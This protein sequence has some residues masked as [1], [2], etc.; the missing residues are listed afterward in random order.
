[1]SSVQNELDRLLLKVEKPARYIGGE[2]H[3]VV[4]T[5]SADTVRFAFCFPDLYEIGMS[6]MGLN[7]LYHLLNRTD[8]TYCERCFTPA[9]D[10]SAAMK[11]AGV[12]LFTLETKTPLREMDFV[13]FTLQYELCYTN[14]LAMLDLAGIPALSKDRGEEDPIVICGGPCVYNAEPVADFM[15]VIL[16]G[17]GEELLPEICRIWS[18]YKGSGRSKDEF[19]K[20]IAALQ[21]VYIPKFYEPVRDE[22]GTFRGYR[23]LWDGAPDRVLKAIVRD[24]D[25]VDFPKEL[26]VPLIEVVHDRAVAELFRGCTRGCRFC[27]AGM[28]YRPVRERSMEKVIDIAKTQLENSGQGELSLLSLSTSD[29]TQFEPLV[30]ELMQYCK[31]RQVSLSL[32]SLRMDNFSFRVLD[33]I[34]GVRKTG[35][36]FAAEAGT[37]RLRDVI[38]KNVTEE[39]IFTALKQAFDLG[40][41]SV[42]LYFMM[43]L[44]TETYEDLDGIVDLARRIMELAKEHNGGK[45]GRYSVSVSVSNFVPKP[46]TPFMWVRQNTPEEFELKHYYLKDRL[47]KIK[48]VNFRYHGSYAS[49][50]EAVFAR[51]GRELSAA[52]LRAY[53]LGAS[54]DAWTEGFR[55]DAWEQALA[56]CG[57]DGDYFAL[58]DIDPDAP[59]PWDIVDCGITKDFFKE[60]WRRAQ[61]AATTPDCRYGCNGCGVNAHTECRWGGIYADK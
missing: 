19:L 42:K 2:L 11:Q 8:H 5:A 51:G 34:Q 7:I 35:L 29:Y 54:F 58:N 36:T 40:W 25:P 18:G 59:M 31:A 55:Q 21:G 46:D 49:M 32:P 4:R 57:I 28:V 22:N 24:I 27:Q 47:K 3:S 37:Q 1:M 6:Y 38:N 26:I 43:G 52:L 41:T 20:E 50:L 61:A 14:I 56:D 10:M 16:I 15:D 39:H 30:T 45:V 23:K 48:G 12:P 60:E 53:E 17:D 33:E 9:R 13:G 44:P